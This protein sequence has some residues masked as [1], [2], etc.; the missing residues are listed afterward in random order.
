VGGSGGDAAV[1]QQY[2]QQYSVLLYSLRSQG[3]VRTLGFSGEVLGVQASSRLLVVSLK[4]QL[5]AF[6]AL[7][8]QHTFSCLTYT[9]P[10]PPLLAGPAGSS[11][12]GRNRLQQ[13]QHFVTD[14]LA[15]S[16]GSSNGA[17]QQQGE[18]A[19]GP[20]HTA[21]AASSPFAL[22]PRWLAYAADTPVPAAGSQPVAQR[23]PLARRDSSGGRGSSATAAAAALDADSQQQLGSGGPSSAA[24]PQLANGLTKAA[25]A[26]AALQ[27]AA[28]G[29]QQLKAGLTAVGTA[30]FKYLSLQ[31]Q[32]WR[33]GQPQQRDVD[34]QEVIAWGVVEGEQAGRR[35]PLGASRRR[36]SCTGCCAVGARI[37][38]RLRALPLGGVCTWRHVL[39]LSALS[40]AAA[41]TASARHCSLLLIVQPAFLAF[42][43]WSCRLFYAHSD[44]VLHPFPLQ[45]DAAV[46]GT[47][48]V[49]DVASRLVVAHFRAHTSPLAALLFSQAGTLLATA[50]VAGHS[51]NL[52]R[53]VPPCPA[54]I[55]PAA[56]G[57]GDVAAGDGG[58]TAG[59][60]VHL[61]RLYRGVTPAAIRDIAIAPD[62]GW[63]AASSGR[64]TTHLF[65][66]PA[67]APG[68]KQPEAQQHQLSSQDQQQAPA[69]ASATGVVGLPP[70]T[71]AAGRARKPGLLS[72]GVAGAATS[73]ARNLYAGQATG[74]APG[75]TVPLLP[76]GRC[77]LL[78]PA[79][80]SCSGCTATG[81]PH[82]QLHWARR[83][84]SRWLH[85]LASWRAFSYVFDLCLCVL[86]SLLLQMPPPSLLRSWHPALA[87]QKQLWGLTA[88]GVAAAACWSSHTMG[89]SP[90]T[91]SALL[92]ARTL[93]RLL[94]ATLLP[95]QTLAA[96]WRLGWTKPSLLL[97]MLLL[98]RRF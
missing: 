21:T 87:A 61:Y 18:T 81:Q 32:T 44:A 41:L 56:A 71:L 79:A 84:V 3:Y 53:I 40:A 85:L 58:G 68:G 65:H 55:G 63:V 60:A 13:P 37:W 97:A 92:P 82:C 78:A 62:E 98:L 46:A 23:L 86:P 64:G 12:S 20:G 25:V 88:V 76:A 83:R 43:P 59:Y 15:S 19:A 91:C 89:C 74:E 16:G 29:G 26:D 17:Q 35:L 14:G 47:V 80:A 77:C 39:S 8:L 42:T 96:A 73:A 90:V 95:H 57:G 36:C 1:Q 6:D 69:A 66:T 52:F 54:A 38:F 93:P 4:G 28:K 30:S 27:A 67:A 51:I 45:A 22:G 94:A 50:S 70:K 49:R 33:Q 48:V 9:P 10:P 24:A 7:T 34:A 31:Y 72:G 11:G 5:Q 2:A 75:S